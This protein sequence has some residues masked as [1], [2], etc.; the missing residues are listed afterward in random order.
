MI[1]LAAFDEVIDI[2]GIALRIEAMLPEGVRARQLSVRTL[3]GGVCLTQADG[4]PRI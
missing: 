1:P 3:M 4:G 2:S